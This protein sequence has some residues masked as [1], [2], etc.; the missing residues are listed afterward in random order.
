MSK[1]LNISI[2]ILRYNFGANKKALNILGKGVTSLG[3]LFS[4]CTNITKKDLDV[5]LKDI[6]IEAAEINLVCPDD[7]G[8]CA[9]IFAEYVAAGKWENKSVVA[10][11]SID[12]I[13]TFVLKGKLSSDAFSNL[14]Q[15]IESTKVLP[16]FRTTGVHGKFFAN[17][18]S[19][20]ETTNRRRPGCRSA[21]ARMIPLRLGS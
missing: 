8:N 14:K 12:P 18:G 5:L 17:C 13:G 4:N 3:F 11:A 10:S 19:S 2:L 15:V 21:W 6:C 7:S 16:K 20:N 9:N 1:E